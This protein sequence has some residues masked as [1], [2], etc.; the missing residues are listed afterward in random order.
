MART[1]AVSAALKSRIAVKVPHM[2]D[3]TSGVPSLSAH[4]VLSPEGEAA[5]AKAA[6]LLDDKFG[7]EHVTLQVDKTV[8]RGDR[9]D[10]GLQ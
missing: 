5:R 8:C 9:D 3:I 1:D 2:Y 10:H 7:I 4:V 6:T